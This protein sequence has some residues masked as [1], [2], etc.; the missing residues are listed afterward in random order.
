MDQRRRGLSTIA[1]V[2]LIMALA[3]DAKA[4]LLHNEVAKKVAQLI[5]LLHDESATEYQEARGISIIKLPRGPT[6]AIAVFTLESF[7][8]GNNYTQFLAVFATTRVPHDTRHVPSI[9]PRLALID[10][11]AVWGRLWRHV[12]SK[13]ISVRKSRHGMLMRFA[14]VEFTPADAACCPS[15]KAHATYTVALW[16]G[17]R[18]KEVKQ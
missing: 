6:V 12:A 14:T 1:G 3:T 15:Q 18:L 7:S 2:L 8:F 13:P 4:G 5:D 10:L 16:P 11:A 17:A 9:P